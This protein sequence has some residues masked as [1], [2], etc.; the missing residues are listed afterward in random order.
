MSK[1][2]PLNH[3][4]SPKHPLSELKTDE[5]NPRIILELEWPS[6]QDGW[7][8]TGLDLRECWALALIHI[9]APMR[10]AVAI[11]LLPCPVL[12]K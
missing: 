4:Q 5:H 10:L 8:L 2:L 1:I 12:P 6:G 7:D 9:S 3:K 11:T